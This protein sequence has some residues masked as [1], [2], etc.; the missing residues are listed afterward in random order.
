MLHPN[1]SENGAIILRGEFK[2]E[3]VGEKYLQLNVISDNDE[4]ILKSFSSSSDWYKAIVGLKTNLEIYANKKR[5]DK[6]KIPGVYKVDKT[7]SIDYNKL[8]EINDQNIPVD[9]YA[10]SASGNGSGF[11]TLI[12]GN[13]IGKVTPESD[14]VS[15]HIIKAVPDLYQGELKVIYADNPLSEKVSIRHSGDFAAEY[16]KYDFEWRKAYPVDGQSP[17]F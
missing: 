8:A 17:K 12:T 14:P 15:I 3:I 16:K 7:I 5:A 13:G 2:D 9:S 11:V 1:R 4:E 10:L 6:S